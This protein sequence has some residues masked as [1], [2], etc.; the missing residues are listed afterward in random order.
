MQT[1]AQRAAQHLH[2]ASALRKVASEMRRSD[3]KTAETLDEIA[4]DYERLAAKLT[5]AR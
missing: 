2:N 1:E 5:T 4:A 3:P